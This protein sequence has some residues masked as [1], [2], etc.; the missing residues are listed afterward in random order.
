[1]AKPPIEV[2]G[3]KEFR[4]ELKALGPEWPKMLAKANK[5][6]AQAIVA[7]AKAKTSSLSLTANSG[8]PSGRVQAKVADSIRAAQ[9]QVAAK[10]M[11]GGP[12]YPYVFGALLGSNKSQQFPSHIGNDWTAGE[13]GG[14]YGIG[15]AIAEMIPT[16]LEIYRRNMAELTAKAFPD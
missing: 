11:A 2:V 14:P 9:S 6:T 7:P 1:M 12:A 10:V 4:A 5:E 16:V 15:D 3:L 13:P 8:N